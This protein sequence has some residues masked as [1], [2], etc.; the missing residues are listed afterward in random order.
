MIYKAESGKKKK[1]EPGRRAART[2]AALALALFPAGLFCLGAFLI[3]KTR[4]EAFIYTC[5]GALACLGAAALALLRALAFRPR[6]LRGRTAAAL[7]LFSWGFCAL[8]LISGLVCCALPA[9][10]NIVPL[11]VFGLLLLA[12]L[13]LVIAVFAASRRREPARETVVNRSEV[14]RAML[15]ELG[16]ILSRCPVPRARELISSVNDA[17]VFSDPLSNFDTASCEDAIARYI[18]QLD[19]LDLND[20]VSVETVCDALHIQI[21]RRNE[22]CAQI[23]SAGE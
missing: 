18:Y 20:L 17:L 14:M 7:S 3:I 10:S 2:A 8:V 23:R 13:S 15:D 12:Y 16:S 21:D 9:L 19:S 22:I 11:I 4:N 6:H 5:C 1:R